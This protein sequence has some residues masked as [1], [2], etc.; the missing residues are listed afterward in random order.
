MQLPI[1]GVFLCQSSPSKERRNAV[2][3]DPTD[4]TT[5]T[6][7][8]GGIIVGMWDIYMIDIKRGK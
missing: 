2:L 1:L 6:K 8:P 7:E 3:P 5:V 4:P